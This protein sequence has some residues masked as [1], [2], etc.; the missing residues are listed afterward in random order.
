MPVILEPKDYQRWL[1]P[2]DPQ[3]LP[4]DLLKPYPAELMEAWKVSKDVG[5]VRNNHPGLCVESLVGEDEPVPERK[6]EESPKQG[7]LFE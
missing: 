4:I 5:N 7:G 1:E 3:R 2:G 6:E